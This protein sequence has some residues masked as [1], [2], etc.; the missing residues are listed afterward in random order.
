MPGRELCGEVVVA[1]IGT[2][3]EVLDTIRP[4]VFANSPVLWLGRLFR[5]RGGG[6]QKHR[7]PAAGAGVDLAAILPDPRKPAVL[8]GPGNGVGQATRGYVEAALSSKRA[9]VLDAD[10]LTSFEGEAEKLLSAGEEG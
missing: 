3:V 5:P 1:D 10:A 4:R 8:V 2:P 9:C 7:G 6:P